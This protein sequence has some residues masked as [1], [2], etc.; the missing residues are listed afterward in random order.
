M[1]DKIADIL[2]EIEI[3]SENIDKRKKQKIEQEAIK[4]H[5]ENGKEP[6]CKDISLNELHILTCIAHNSDVTGIKMAEITGMT[7]GGVSK[8]LARLE[9]KKLI[10]A[11]QKETSRKKLFYKLTEN[12]HK[13]NHIH[14]K[15]HNERF[16]FY[17]SLLDEFTPEE[18][19]V[20]YSFFCG[21]NRK[22]KT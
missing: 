8:I 15:H 4:Y 20:L 12:G 1:N 16:S 7:R 3:F 17:S 14:Q 2:K 22:D 6:P 21:V 13:I 11:Y 18:Q 5:S 10:E 19:N 9:S